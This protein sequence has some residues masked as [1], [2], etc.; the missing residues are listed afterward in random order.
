MAK[1][2]TLN[3]IR[4]EKTFGYVQPLGNTYSSFTQKFGNK[5]YGV[6]FHYNHHRGQWFC[7]P[8]DHKREYFNGDTYKIG[9]GKN[10]EEAFNDLYK[11]LKKTD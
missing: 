5:L 6:L 7:F 9:K 8:S 3:E 1:K 4:Q 11:N 10:P 2:R